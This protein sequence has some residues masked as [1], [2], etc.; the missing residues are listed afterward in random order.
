MPASA[1][2]IS[3]PPLPGGRPWPSGPDIASAAFDAALTGKLPGPGPVAARAAAWRDGGGTLALRHLALRW[4]KL[5]LSGS[6]TMGLDDHLQPA[7]TATAALAGYDATLDALAASGTLAP[8][9]VQ[10]V[11]AVLAILARPPQG[12]G[13]RQVELPVTLH[14]RT[15]AAAGFPLLRLPEFLWP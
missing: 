8:R 10:A 12:G 14:D 1:E 2:D 11:K 3:L 9:A 5:G 4:G 15:L 6:A 13:P 7:G